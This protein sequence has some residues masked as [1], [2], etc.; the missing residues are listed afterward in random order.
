VEHAGRTLALGMLTE[1][2]S[3]SY[4]EHKLAVL[5]KLDKRLDRHPLTVESTASQTQPGKGV[6]ANHEPIMQLAEVASR[7]AWILSGTSCEHA[8]R[9]RWR[10]H[11]LA[12]SQPARCDRRYVR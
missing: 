1:E 8:P 2:L 3:S 6:S 5:R 7:A 10:R 9:T 12:P 11:H 4:A